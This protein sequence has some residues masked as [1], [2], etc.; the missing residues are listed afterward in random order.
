M[1]LWNEKKEHKFDLDTESIAKNAEF[2]RFEGEYKRCKYLIWSSYIELRELVTVYVNSDIS[3]FESEYPKSGSMWH[4]DIW[5]SFNSHA[6]IRFIL[7]FFLKTEA[8]FEL[9]MNTLR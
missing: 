8:I 3:I 2:T 6:N 1:C 7:N 4:Y 5:T 9:K